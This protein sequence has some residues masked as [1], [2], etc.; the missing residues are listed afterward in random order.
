MKIDLTK[1][2]E[3][4]E[5]AV[6]AILDAVRAGNLEKAKLVTC[7]LS[8]YLSFLETMDTG[9]L[10]SSAGATVKHRTLSRLKE[11]EQSLQDQDASARRA[12]QRR[13]TV[14]QARPPVRP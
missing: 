14:R 4:I 3:P 1:Y 7:S 2:L 5:V 13:P 12:D 8:V 11:I 9:V 6:P 10:D